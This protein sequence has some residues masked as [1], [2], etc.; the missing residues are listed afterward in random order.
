MYLVEGSVLEGN[1]DYARDADGDL[2]I[3]FDL[4]KVNGDICDGAAPAVETKEFVGKVLDL[5]AF[6]ICESRPSRSGTSGRK[7]G[8]EVFWKI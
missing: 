5:P 3:I 4:K 7:L 1:A 2:A 6:D 8:W